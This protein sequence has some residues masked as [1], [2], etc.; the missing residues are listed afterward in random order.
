MRC[1]RLVELSEDSLRTLRTAKVPDTLV[2]KLSPLKDEVF[3][4]RAK[5]ETKLTGVLSESELKEYR[6]QILAPA[7]TGRA[8]KAGLH[9][10]DVIT[11]FNGRP[12]RDW[13]DL[14]RAIIDAAPEKISRDANGKVTGKAVPL[15]VVP[16]A[17]PRRG[18]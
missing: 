5:L 6:S 2:D 16:P 4:D 9:A 1:R 8:A 7:E 17:R 11:E 13:N 18:S 15:T 12:V 10:G 3:A 14:A